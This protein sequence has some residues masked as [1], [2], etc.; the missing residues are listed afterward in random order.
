LGFARTA[1]SKPQELAS[2]RRWEIQQDPNPV[3]WRLG[4]RP[5]T[6][7]DPAD[8]GLVWAGQ[9]LARAALNRELGKVREIGRCPRCSLDRTA[10][11][12]DDD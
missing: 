8:F 6:S 1:Q 5:S 2:F 9:S 11:V 4:M 3:K 10:Q 12:W 7:D